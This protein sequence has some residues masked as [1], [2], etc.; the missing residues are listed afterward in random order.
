M[1]HLIKLFA[2]NRG[3][4]CFKAEKSADEATVYV[5]DYITSDDYFGGVSAIVH[6]G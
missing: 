4:G 6:S 2:D 1:N 3:R 5:Y